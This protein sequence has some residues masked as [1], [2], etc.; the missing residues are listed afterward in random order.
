MDETSGGRRNMIT[1]HPW[2]GN[3]QDN[4][5]NKT[6]QSKRMTAINSV[7]E[8]EKRNVQN[9]SKSGKKKW[10]GQDDIVIIRK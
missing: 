10:C 2:T 8:P 3:V 5:M 1:G 9:Y 7:E 4:G 6:D